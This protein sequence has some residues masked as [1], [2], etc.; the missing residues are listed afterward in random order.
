MDHDIQRVKLARHRE[1]AAREV[2]KWEVEIAPFW[3]VPPGGQKS[4]EKCRFLGPGGRTP[5]N[6]LLIKG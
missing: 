6:G 4:N 3:G 2:E 1:V 5:P